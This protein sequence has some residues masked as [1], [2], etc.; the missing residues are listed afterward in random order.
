MN[1]REEILKILKNREDAVTTRDLIEKTGHSRQY[2]NRFFKKLVEEG[3]IKPVISSVY[4]WKDANIVLDELNG[5][6]A[7]GRLVL[8]LIEMVSSIVSSSSR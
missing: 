1:I 4:P 8:T 2:I 3:K 7:V 5:Q 6:A